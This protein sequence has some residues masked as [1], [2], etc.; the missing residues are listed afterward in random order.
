[1]FTSN[2]KVFLKKSKSLIGYY[3]SPFSDSIRLWRT[4]HKA[5]SRKVLSFNRVNI[6]I[7][8]KT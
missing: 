3:R 2:L 7:D 6:I 1:V 4:F 5:Y 8:G